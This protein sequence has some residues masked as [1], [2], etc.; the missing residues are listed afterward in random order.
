MANNK[1]IEPTSPPNYKIFFVILFIFIVFGILV[2]YIYYIGNNTKSIIVDNVKATQNTK[3]SST[4][5][6]KT[7]DLASLMPSSYDSL[8]PYITFYKNSKDNTYTIYK[9]N[10]YEGLLST[11]ISNETKIKADMIKQYYKDTDAN[12]YN[13]FKDTS[14]KNIDLRVSSSTDNSL[15]VYGLVNREY[16]I[17]SKSIDFWQ[18]AYTETIK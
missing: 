1:H 15:I 2:A 8:S 13:E 10:S 16:L 18:Q 11:L 14:V 7:T 12:N 4:V 17:F 5:M 6:V 3:A 9:V